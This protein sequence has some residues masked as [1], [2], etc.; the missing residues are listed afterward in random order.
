MT[1]SIATNLHE[2]SRSEILAD[3]LFSGWGTITPVR[4]QDDHGI[5]LYGGLTER[6]GQ[7]SF[8]T[9][10]YVVQVK[11][12]TDSW[13][14]DGEE[15]VRWLVDYPIPIF[16][17]CVNKKEGTLS[18][19]HVTSR[20]VVSV[21]DKVPARLE[22]VPETHDFGEDVQWK[23]GGKFSLSAPIL[24]VTL[25]D[26]LDEEKL[27]K[28]R[29]VFTRWIRIDQENIDRLRLGLPSFRMPSKYTVN[30][31]PPPNCDWTERGLTFP[32]EE[33]FRRS[34]YI[35]NEC[36][37]NYGTQLSFHK[38]RKG[39]LL[40]TLFSDH[41]QKQHGSVF[42]EM[43]TSFSRLSSI[44]LSTKLDEIID[45]LNPKLDNPVKYVYSGLD[46][47]H[48]AFDDVPIVKNFLNKEDY[49]IG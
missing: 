14:F 11:S 26:F 19:Y 18:I 32:R 34:I 44:R 25:D 16:L 49:W 8:I 15:S 9:D 28:L 12:T 35:L 17:S 2:G 47:V 10:Y 36:L 21:L 48:Q 46:K 43:Q 3:Y 42:S 13:I 23:D 20:F 24:R 29:G 37:E 45:G 6:R 31:T 41:I 22:L 1:G 39:A 4:R 38:D 27:K 40:A 5:D 30:E 33:L 7:R